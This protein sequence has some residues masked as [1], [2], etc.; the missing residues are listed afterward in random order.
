MNPSSV[1]GLPPETDTAWW[2]EALSGEPLYESDGR[3]FFVETPSDVAIDE[4]QDVPQ[5]RWTN[6]RRH[7]Y[8]W[9]SGTIG[10]LNPQSRIVDVGCGPSQFADLMN[11]H[12]TCGVD[13]VPYRGVNIVADLGQPLP[14]A[15][16]CADAVVL[17]NVLEH[18]YEPHKL[19]ADLHRVLKPG[20]VML[21]VVPFLIKLHQT[22]YD[23]HRYTRYALERMCADNGFSRTRV[24]EIGNLF[25]V[26]EIDQRIRTRIILRET[27]GHRRFLARGLLWLQ[28]KT[29]RVLYKILPPDTLSAR[30]TDGFP[31]SY[32][33]HAVK[34]DET[35]ASSS[36]KNT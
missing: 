26:F 13:I 14:L 8:Q 10:A 12:A 15:D 6:M 2:R 4:Q 27:A 35:A 7:H 5:S 3:V 29:D 32:G 28:R 16:N 34:Q 9:L 20:G 31:Q 24:D 23:F 25:D 19:I 1:D 36:G 17:S 11:G 21:V 18:I 33:V 22:P 30:D